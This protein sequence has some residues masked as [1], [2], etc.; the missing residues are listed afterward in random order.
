MLKV[1][2]CVNELVSDLNRYELVA[3]VKE[4]TLDWILWVKLWILLVK[5]LKELVVTNELVSTPLAF[6]A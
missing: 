5:L 3:L 6:K 2:N 4:S 1:D